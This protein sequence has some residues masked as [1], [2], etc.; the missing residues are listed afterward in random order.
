M[1]RQAAGRNS[2]GDARKRGRQCPSCVPGGPSAAGR[3]GFPDGRVSAGRFGISGPAACHPDR[4]AAA[5]QENRAQA[6][7][8]KSPLEPQKAG[9]VH[10]PHAGRSRRARAPR[11]RPVCRHG[12]D[13]GRRRDQGLRKNC[14][15]G[16][17]HVIRSR[18]TAGPGQQ[19]HRLRRRKPN[20]AA[21]QAR[22]RSVAEG[23][24]KGEGSSK[25]FG[26]RADSAL[27]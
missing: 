24:G 12:A 7:A 8:Q 10:G 13:E 6:E 9:V 25:G 1:R 20:R 3:A 4:G 11:H 17:G 14:L 21:Q 23:K 18:D 5:R 27:C 26:C 2:Q 19:V 22:G 15:S 16:H